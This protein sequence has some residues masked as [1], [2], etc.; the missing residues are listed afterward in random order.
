MR[1]LKANDP[2]AINGLRGEDGRRLGR[3]RNK[4]GSMSNVASNDRSDK[5]TAKVAEEIAS[6]N[7]LVGGY[8]PNR[9]KGRMVKNPTEGRRSDWAGHVHWYLFDKYHIELEDCH[10]GEPIPQGDP[11]IFV[12][13][14]DASKNDSGVNPYGL[15]E[16]LVNNGEWFSKMWKGFWKYISGNK[17]S[18]AADPSMDRSAAPSVRG[19]F[20]EEGMEARRVRD[21]AR[22][23][24][25]DATVAHM[26]RKLNYLRKIS[27]FYDL[28]GM[29]NNESETRSA[30]VEGSFTVAS[31]AQK[32]SQISAHRHAQKVKQAEAAGQ[33]P[34]PPPLPDDPDGDLRATMA[35]VQRV[36]Q[37]ET[38]NGGK[39]AYPF[40]KVYGPEVTPNT[41]VTI[42]PHDVGRLG[43]EELL[44]PAAASGHLDPSIDPNDLI[45]SRHQTAADRARAY[46]QQ[47]EE[48]PDEEDEELSQYG[49][50]PREAHQ[51]S[52]VFDLM[53]HWG[54]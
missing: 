43:Q 30:Y 33:Q 31:L 8:D 39:D 32:L 28:L 17:R 48:G 41:K 4:S 21:E 45:A 6:A 7:K 14:E 36:K 42:V 54:F 44:G 20:A 37:L 11:F 18:G 19:G 27:K 51:W 26:D 22:K 40:M 47:T 9:R 46:L 2:N 5:I 3:S 52:D 53:E 50:E 13:H 10:T 34:P 25:D 12:T 29:N 38:A 15:P 16:V 23:N 49:R 35:I 1:S 24:G